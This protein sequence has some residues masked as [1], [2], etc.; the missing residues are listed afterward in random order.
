MAR[1]KPQSPSARIDRDLRLTKLR[2]EKARTAKLEAEA[3]TSSDYN[4]Y[5]R[6]EE[7]KPLH[8]DD[9]GIYMHRFLRLFVPRWAVVEYKEGYGPQDDYFPP[10][11]DFDTYQESGV[12]DDLFKDE[13][14]L[15]QC[16]GCTCGG[17]TCKRPPPP[18]W[19]VEKQG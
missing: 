15:C 6:Y 18:S 13:L 10:P 16:P 8:P 11:A 9:R 14:G 2:Q 7:M 19:P 3:G 4:P 5:M 12:I 17:C 1:R